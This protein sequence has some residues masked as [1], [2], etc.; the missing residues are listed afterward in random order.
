MI[1][2]KIYAELAGLRARQMLSDALLILWVVVWV[3]V[4]MRVH[5]LVDRLAGPGERIE[6]A[7]RSFRGSVERLGERADDLP[8]IGDRLQRSFETVAD[9]GRSLQQ[10]GATQQDVVHTL[11]LWLGIFIAAL[12]ILW[13]LARYVPG[14][15]AWIREATAASRLRGELR[16]FA[17]RALTTRPLT[18]LARV[19]ANPVADYEAGDYR[20]LAALELSRLG[21]LT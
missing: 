6:S 19:S 1:G 17:L 9:G 14:R 13:L 11:A 10:A 15:I 20:A 21:L 16:L 4:G 12:P 2:M 8:V 7:G 5:D 3:R 18:E